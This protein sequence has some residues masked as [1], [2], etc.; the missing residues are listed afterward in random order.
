M[1]WSIGGD[2]ILEEKLTLPNII[3]KFNANLTGFST[4]ENLILK[5]KTRGNFNVAVS[6]SEALDMESQAK[7]LI[8]R[9][10]STKE[11]DYVNDWKLVTMFIGGNDLSDFCLDKDLH[12]PAAYVA[13]LQEAL[14]LMQAQLPNTLVNLVSVLDIHDL[15]DMNAGVACRELHKSECPCAAYPVSDEEEEELLTYIRNYTMLTEQLVSSG[16]YDTGNNFTVVLQPFYREYVAPRL[17]DGKVDLSWFAP[18]C[19]H[20]SAKSHGIY[21]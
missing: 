5:P 10:K 20:F 17:P 14:D 8:Q 3:K 2:S 11:I 6:G 9:L 21:F 1:S 18:D 4:G 12:A 16:R 13:Y 15:K 7:V 19:F